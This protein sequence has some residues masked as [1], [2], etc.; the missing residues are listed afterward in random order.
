MKNSTSI[1]DNKI[2]DVKLEI[3][4]YFELKSKND[5]SKITC[6]VSVD[7]DICKVHLSKMYE[8]I[9]DKVNFEDLTYLSKVLNTTKINLGDSYYRS[10]CDTCDFGSRD[11]LTITCLDIKI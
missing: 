4:N 2:N 3:I 10:G 1:T 7:N 6:N 5:Y 8:G 9:Q 11:E